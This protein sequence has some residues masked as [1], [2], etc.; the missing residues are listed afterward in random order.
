MLPTL[1]KLI[2]QMMKRHLHEQKDQ[3]IQKEL[4]R[5][6]KNY[7]QTT[8][9]QIIDLRADLETEARRLYPV[10]DSSV[11]HANLRRSRY[12]F[13]F[14]ALFGSLCIGIPHGLLSENPFSFF[15]PLI[16]ALLTWIISCATIPI[17]YNQRVKG[18]F[19][20]VTTVYIYKNKLDKEQS[21][22]ID[23]S[24]TM[25]TSAL[26]SANHPPHCA[27][28]E[29]KCTEIETEIELEIPLDVI[30]EESKDI[31]E[32]NILKPPPDNKD[33]GTFLSPAP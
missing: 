16:M 13:W 33:Y 15:S 5:F 28:Q 12:I 9:N 19:H 27:E 1:D 21:F 11:L 17:L 31:P 30:G 22:K 25:M 8:G 2:K 23:H 7:P 10:V 29:P 32:K 26:S 20:S 14:I 18:G 6:R 3:F 4:R 24:L